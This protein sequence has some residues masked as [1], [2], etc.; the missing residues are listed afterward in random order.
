VAH[1]KTFVERQS[2]V[3]FTLYEVHLQGWFQRLGVVVSYVHLLI[4][5]P[6]S[7]FIN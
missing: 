3:C 1:F 7:F 2:A 4:D 5:C 6:F